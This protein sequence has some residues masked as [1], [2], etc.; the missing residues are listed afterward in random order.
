MR[1]FLAVVKHE[2]KK[3]VYKW[4]FL[5]GT[6]L[7]PV[8]AACFAVVPALIF[9]IKG[10]PTRIVI[11]D[12]EGKIAPR[13]KE[14]LSAESINAKMLDAAKNAKVDLTK[15]QAEQMN[16]GAGSIGAGF[17]FVDYQATGKTD[18]QIRADLTQLAMDGKIDA[19]LIMPEKGVGTYDLLSRK[20]GD[21]VAGNMIDDALNAAVRAI[22][23]A[24]V[25][26][27]L[28]S[29]GGSGQPFGHRSVGG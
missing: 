21:F 10:E 16:Q 14:N 15:S 19:Y 25:A 27:G 5:L 24:D 23:L 7:L 4:T 12:R 9:S 6:L 1:K 18:E 11:V 3:I 28:L 22:H 8:L 17:V 26:A 20:A 13:L 2:Y 29:I